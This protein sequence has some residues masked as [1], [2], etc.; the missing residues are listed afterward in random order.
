MG[1]VKSWTRKSCPSLSGAP[2]TVSASQDGSPKVK[3]VC[4]TCAE[5][6][7]TLGYH[8]RLPVLQPREKLRGEDGEIEKHGTNTVHGVWGGFSGCNKLPFG[9]LGR[10]QRV[11]RRLR[12][13]QP[14]TSFGSSNH[15]D[16]SFRSKS[17]LGDPKIISASFNHQIPP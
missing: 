14:S 13:C 5:N 2:T 8:V 10:V 7:C 15:P 11:D 16:K 9:A 6:H 12:S 3:E 4:R 17:T 1:S